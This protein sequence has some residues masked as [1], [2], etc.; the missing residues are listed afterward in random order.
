MKI[1][2]S[3]SRGKYKWTIVYETDEGKNEWDELKNKYEEMGLVKN[4]TNR[5]FGQNLPEGQSVEYYQETTDD[6]LLNKLRENPLLGNLQ[7]IDAINS[8]IIQD[9]GSG[10]YSFNVAVLRAVPKDNPDN[11]SEK[12]AVIEGTGQAGLNY[13]KA[14]KTSTEGMKLVYESMFNT[15][16][17]VEVTLK[18]RRLL[19]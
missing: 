2:E 14:G 17:D 4:T 19:V 7:A 15:P 9:N 8:P 16:A 3:A 10:R 13:V 11:P 1:I 5:P 18:P 12:V 6:M